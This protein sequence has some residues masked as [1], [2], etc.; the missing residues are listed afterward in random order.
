M[1]RPALLIAILFSCTCSFKIWADL[2]EATAWSPP[3]K[4]LNPHVSSISNPILETLGELE[5]N[6]DPKC[7]ATATRLESLIYGTPLSDKARYSKTDFQK[8]FVYTLWTIAAAEVEE[9][10]QQVTSENVKKAVPNVLAIKTINPQITELIFSDFALQISKRDELHY[11]SIAYSLR[12]IM[13]VQQEQLLL[14]DGDL[15]MLSTDAVEA[16]KQYTDL[17]TLALLQL[18]DQQ[19]RMADQYEIDEQTIVRAWAKLFPEFQHSSKENTVAVT[20]SN[21]TGTL[22]KLIEQ[23]VASYAA[24]NNINVELFARNLQVYFAYATLPPDPINSTQFQEAFKQA[25]VGFAEALYLEAQSLEE[26][27]SVISEASVQKAL[28]RLLPHNVNSYEDVIYFPNFPK[29]RQVTIEAYDLDAFRDS[30]LHWLYLANGLDI[31][32]ES[33]TK[34]ADP[35]AA[36]LLTEGIADYALLLLRE[37][38]K[39]AKAEQKRSQA[40]LDAKYIYQT[41]QNLAQ[42]IGQYSQYSSPEIN[43]EPIVSAAD[44]N[45]DNTY[46]T[47]IDEAYGLNFEHRSSDWLSR[48][49]RSYL[50]VGNVG[51]ITIPPA[52]GGAGVATE[53]INNDGLIDVL[54]LSGAGNQLLFNT[55]TKLVDKTA[56]AGLNW[57]RPKDGLPG[58]PRQP[59]IAD[60]DNDGLQ[61]I[62]ITYVNDTHRVYKN[63]GDGTFA[64]KTEI[65]SLGGIG[66]I[67]GPAT[68]L[69]V[70][71]DGLLD[72][73][74]VYF[75]NYLKGELP[76]LARKNT[77]GIQ[78]ELYINQGDFK[79]S[80][81]ND[82][83]G[84]NNSGWGQAVTHTDLNLDGWQDL[85]VGND[86]GINAYYINRKGKEFVDVAEKLGTDKPSYTMN[87]S[88][89]D[90]NQDGLADVYISNITT[91][92]KDE[93]YVLPSKD[94]PFKFD[95]D[96][97]ANMRV[98]ENN[99]LFLSSHQSGQ[100]AYQL[101]DSIGR[102][103][104]ST[105]WAWDADFF[106]VDNDGDDDLYVVNG[107]NDYYVYSSTNSYQSDE[108]IFPDAGKASNV[109]YLN[110]NGKLNNLSKTSGLDVVANSRSVSYLD[111]ENDGDLD[112]LINNY[113]DSAMLFKNNAEKLANNWLKI[114]LQ[115]APDKGVNLDAIGAQ[116]LVGYG[117]DGYVWRQVSS[118]QGYMS[119]HPKV[120]HIGLSK[121]EKARV[122]V[123]WPNGKKESFGV[124]PANKSYTL[125][126]GL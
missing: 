26:N 89:T 112:V 95:P 98:I 49:M 79:F 56:S 31:L 72:I 93:G 76:T 101:S 54:I 8:Q 7:H 36:E 1:F 113:H 90:L 57:V 92:N 13:S 83:L 117:K 126:Y 30:G 85:I 22:S 64:D 2:N 115:G 4:D 71:N 60:I 104:T 118:S 122:L 109:F 67:G 32:D 114:K 40:I 12:A 27:P 21:I 46:F 107:M 25:M 103:D 100:L 41:N 33:L 84:A 55:G 120:Q 75:G 87:I 16:I 94:T 108:V 43:K 82:A 61:D 102:G 86:F 66:L 23:K 58:E 106:D 44:N 125:K 24:Y 123:I 59:I 88:L 78:N 38:G 34:E 19:A 96:K 80:K 121:A 68:L 45:Q 119:A 74:L 62:I 42:I 124:L 29:S 47:R 20:K 116:I 99:D 65:A 111:L 52:F 69:D 91:M 5:A 35:F 28:D 10:I 3:S 51:N 17:A 18:A 14:E 50:K 6:R 81:S 9:R 73:Y 77:N 48:Q 105:G 11:G 15:P 37:T 110:A 39:L 70:N 97:L 53:D 63:M